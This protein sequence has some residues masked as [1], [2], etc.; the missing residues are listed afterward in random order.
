MTSLA[1]KYYQIFLA[2]GLGFGMGAG[3]VFTSAMVCVGQWFSRRRGLAIGLSSCG[4]SVGGV[5]FPVFLD[6]VIKLVGFYG[7]IRW[8]ALLVGGLLGVACF[9]IRARLPR[10]VWNWETKWFD[11]G[12]FGERQFAF[13]TFGAYFVMFV[14]FFLS[15]F[16]LV[17]QE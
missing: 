3:G 9:L 13:Y 17:K 1:D 11:G 12:L 8:T 10:K 6:R 2:Q 5:V 14:S 7:A 15:F 4:A 16:Y